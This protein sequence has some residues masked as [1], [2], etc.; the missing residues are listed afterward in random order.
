[1]AGGK[2]RA[3]TPRAKKS[4][5]HSDVERLKREIAALRRE[6]AKLR[7]KREH[8]R[9]EKKRLVREIDR[10]ETMCAK[11]KA[12]LEE[13]RRAGKRQAAPFS[14][15]EP[16]ANPRRPGRRAG[17]KYGKRGRQR[18]P[19]QVDEVVDVPLPDSCPDCQGEIEH[20]AVSAQYQVEIPPV[21]P[22]VTR[23]DVHKGTC[24]CCKRPVRGRDPRQ[25]SEA[26]GAAA[27]GLGPNA[28]AIAAELHYGLGL[29][30]GKVATLF[31]HLYE[32]PV[33]RGGIYQALARVGE[34]LEPTYNALQ[35]AIQ[36]A[37]MVVPDET[38]WKV[39]GFLNWL[40]VF[41]TPEATV[42]AVLDGRGFKQASAVLGAD[43]S[44]CLV[45]DG[46]APYDK[47]TKA[48][49][50][51]CFAHLLRR[52]VENL[53]TAHRG[54]ARVPRAVQR[55]LK[56]ALAVRDRRDSGEISTH[57]ARIAAGRLAT[58]MDALLAWKPTDNENRKLL[59]HLRN[60]RDALF[61]FLTVP[62]VDA[63]NW[64]AEQAIRPAVVARKVWGG[65]R[66]WH[67]AMTHENIISFLR[68]AS[69]QGLDSAK[70]L[71]PVLTSK[72]PKVAALRGL[73]HAN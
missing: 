4:R 12:L 54:T 67:G 58:E 6:N 41:A 69:Q 19:K 9:G 22:R 23:F 13:A 2:K 48:T 59:K 65:N 26:R 63:T 64:R 62:G 61:T 70:V 7:R 27:V 56:Q 17:A 28:L 31:R 43:F 71:A 11:L 16:K 57:G 40:W 68:T 44:A 20:E 3:T 29:S 42:Y 30:F 33:T 1:M 32:L 52:C 21:R 5:K 60:Q 10:L 55:I 34:K 8:L 18:I 49:H 51:T 36:S 25:N 14:K 73:R 39:G 15:G 47:F 38:G 66:T 37:P 72:A 46:W 45:R 53:E 35:R 50:Q 24:L